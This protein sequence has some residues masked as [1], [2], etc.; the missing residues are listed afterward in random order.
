V[1]QL[2]WQDAAAWRQHT[3]ADG[4]LPAPPPDPAISHA[5]LI[6]WE[7]HCVEC[8]MPQCYASCSLYVPRA[9]RK[10]ARFAYGIMP[11]RGVS[12]LFPW[13]ADIRFRRW[14]KLQASLPSSLLMPQ[15]ESLQVES[16]LLNGVE[17]AVTA[18]STALRRLSPKRR[19]NGAFTAARRLLLQKQSLFTGQQPPEPHAFF[20]KCYSAE[21]EAFRIQLELV[22]DRPVFRVSLQIQPGW[23]E[24]QL[25]SHELLKPTAGKPG[26]LRLS[27][28]NDREARLVFTWLHFV[29]LQNPQQVL[30]FQRAATGP[31]SSLTAVAP[32]ES[33]K[34]ARR[35]K[36]VAWDLDNT[37]WNGVIGDAGADGVEPNSDMIRLIRH[38]DER[39]ILQ[40]IV[41]K[42]HHEVAWPKIEQLGL[43]D[44][45]LYP[46]IHWGP[47]S[48]SL[49]QIADE[50]N[51]N[52][53]TFAMIDDSPFERHEVSQL[54]PQVRVYD[55]AMGPALIQDSA[56]D[57]PVSAESGTRRLQYLTEARRRRVH[58]SWRGDY[59]EFLRS[60]HMVLKI[61]QP[62]EAEFS[63]CLELLQR[64]NQFNLNGHSYQESDFRQLL[65]SSSQ[66]CFCFEVTDDFGGYGIVGVAAFE[67]TPDGAVLVDFVMSCRVAQKKVEATFLM[68]YAQQSHVARHGRLQARLKVTTRNMPLRDVLDELGFQCLR[69]EDQNQLLQLSLQD[70]ISGPDVM[71]IEDYTANPAGADETDMQ[72]PPSLRSVTVLPQRVA[73]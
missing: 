4:G 29:R 20:L 11:N 24:H 70:S 72:S 65:N 58:Q 19:L 55:P 66:E 23:N 2:T 14:A 52:V 64:S 3:S 21:S 49:Q 50:L 10:C 46:A 67:L 68:W 51:I 26:L 12:G 60:C 33:S 71:Q 37:L 15:V 42:N 43:A 25:D 6:C 13:G 69:K 41:S 16:S 7:E 36:C 47:K 44:Y 5:G 39:G 32:H 57:V 1:F 22:T 18:V 17:R 59:D 54:L 40:T 27:I 53:D 38:F 34:P 30:P 9:D 73:A 56:F 62:G 63:R 45:F 61:R 31:H 28:E 48:R 35:I 8:A